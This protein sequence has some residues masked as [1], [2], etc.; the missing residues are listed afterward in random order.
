MLDGIDAAK[1][2]RGAI[3][4]LFVMVVIFLFIWALGQN[5]INPAAARDLGQ[6]QGSDPEIS[7]WF[8]SVKMPDHPMVSCCG[9]ADAWYADKTETGPNGE[10][11]A[12]IT[13]ER[14]DE[15]L[16]RRHIPVGTKIIVPKHKIQFR[17][18]N[19]VGRPIIFLNPDNQVWCYISVGGV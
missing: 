3:A 17:Y 2:W 8:K 12:I 11:V 15:P 9:E 16:K 4:W 13:D 10:L 19:P 7:A 14:P 1:F 6:W 18:G 5:T